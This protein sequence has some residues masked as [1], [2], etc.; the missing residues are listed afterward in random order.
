M[1]LLT[2]SLLTAVLWSASADAQDTDR[3]QDP[4]GRGGPPQEAVEACAAA[5][6]GDSCSFAGRRGETV[7]G[8]CEAPE[9]M[10][11]ACRPD[12]LPPRETLGDY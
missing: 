7:Q 8:S 12:N 6:Q 11:L 5:S 9:D 4:R 2:L 10:P 3:G 1:K